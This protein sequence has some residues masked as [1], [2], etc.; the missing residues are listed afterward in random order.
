MTALVVLV[1]DAATT[2]GPAALLEAEPGRTVLAR[3][4][5]ELAGFGVELRLVLTRS[6]WREEVAAAVPYTVPV[7]AYVDTAAALASLATFLERTE[8]PVLLAHGNVL[9]HGGVLGDAAADSRLHTVVL[10]QDQARSA[11]GSAGTLVVGSGMILGAGSAE[12]PLAGAGRI[13]AGVLRIDAADRHALAGGI[14]V[15]SGSAAIGGWVDDLV[16]L[17]VL[18]AHRLGGGVGAIEVGDYV[19]ERPRSSAQAAAAATRLAEVD[20]HRVRLRRVARP[21][22]GFYSTFIL[23]R[24]SP[25]LTEIAIKRAWTPNAITMGALGIALAGAAC[26][27]IGDRLGLIVGALLLQVSLVTDCVD[28]ETARYTRTFSALGAWLDATTDR[29]KEYA[30]YA[31]LAI[32]ASRSGESAWTLAGATLALQVFRNFVDVG[33][34]ATLGTRTGPGG[35]AGPPDSAEPPGSPTSAATLGRT[36]ISLSERTSAHQALKW[37]KRMMFLPIGERWLIISVFAALGGARAVFWALLVLGMPSAVYATTGRVLRTFAAR[38]PARDEPVVKRDGELDQLIDVGPI[39]R[40]LSTGWIHLSAPAALGA[41]VAM[42][43]LTAMVAGP[44]HRRLTAYGLVA[45][46]ALAA[47]AWRYP[48][49]GRF[50]WLMPGIVRGLEY[51]LIVRVVAAVDRPAM[52]AAFAVLCAISYHHYDTAY[53]WRHAHVG[54]A[55]WVFRAGL[56]WD[57]RLLVLAAGLLVTPQIGWLLALG[58]SAL[59]AV[60]IAESASGWAKF[61]AR[62]DQLAVTH[63]E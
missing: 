39:G 28:G 13:C 20:E 17:S 41:S 34:V 57:G 2:G 32:G 29:V 62:A 38:A 4:L 26:F 33:F 45:T 52:P 48:P 8:G 37:A 10:T 9:A 53:R 60:F 58:A 7:V 59:A 56:G 54:P 47:P 31:A 6:E 43:L 44:D 19:C 1:D 21:D 63:S 42:A 24:L 30:V 36:A 61:L 18:A 11:P 35:P 46:L 12:Q 23:R 25:R 15:L 5:G 40:A 49:R 51:G 16:D 27:A 14:R 3:L 50:G 22:D 55:P